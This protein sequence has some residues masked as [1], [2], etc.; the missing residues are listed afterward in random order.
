MFVGEYSICHSLVGRNFLGRDLQ[1]KL[2]D[3]SANAA[4]VRKNGENLPKVGQRPHGLRSLIT[5]NFWIENTGRDIVAWVVGDA[6]NLDTF[7]AVARIPEGCNFA[8]ADHLQ[9]EYEQ[10][11]R[12]FSVNKCDF[13]LNAFVTGGPPWMGL[14]KEIGFRMLGTHTY[15]N[16][17]ETLARLHSI[18]LGAETRAFPRP[19]TDAGQN[20]YF[21]GSSGGRTDILES[22]PT[23]IGIRVKER[24]PSIVRAAYDYI[25][26]PIEKVR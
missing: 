25:D 23:R 20:I 12:V 26:W 16:T 18:H 15:G 10:S 9:E 2:H 1:I 19:K 17:V 3:V 11:L 5:Q 14:G 6:H 24:K 22:L 13:S 4:W 8:Q 21:N 7:A